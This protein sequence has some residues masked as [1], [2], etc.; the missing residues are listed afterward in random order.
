M[1]A[2][3]VPETSIVIINQPFAALLHKPTRIAGLDTVAKDSVG[4]ADR[5]MTSKRQLA[6]RRKDPQLIVGPR[7]VQDAIDCIS[8]PDN[9]SPS[10]T[11]AGSCR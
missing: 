8:A 2:R 9:S 6:A 1:P 10:S 7:L 3:G 5:R 4:R 11:T